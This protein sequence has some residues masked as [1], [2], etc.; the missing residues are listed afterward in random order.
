MPSLTMTHGH[1]GAAILMAGV[2]LLTACSPDEPASAGEI[3]E[4]AGE[5]AAYLE[6][7]I[8]A[9]LQLTLF[10]EES[11]PSGAVS[12][13]TVLGAASLEIGDHMKVAGPASAVCQNR[14]CWLSLTGE[15][16]T[17]IRIDVDRDEDGV[18]RF[19]VPV[20]IAGRFVV[21]EGTLAEENLGTTLEEASEAQEEGEHGANDPGLRI[22]ATSVWVAE[23]SA[24]AEDE[25]V[26]P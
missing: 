4:T 13:E 17:V 12:V 21:A 3:T 1:A 2:F 16:G 18:Y 20:D 9:G 11:D 23:D 26:L 14:G 19:T 5:T 24:G 15:D 6:D 25:G 8:P 10:G 7:A 22:V